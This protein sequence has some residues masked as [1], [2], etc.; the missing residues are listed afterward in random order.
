MNT[1]KQLTTNLFASVLAFLVNGGISFFLTP[2]ITKTLG[3]EAYGF[4]LLGTNIIS[5]ATL[6]TIALNSMAGRF[7]TIE[8]H[9]GN[10]YT[11]NRYFTSVVIAN[12]FVAL[13][14]LV[15]TCLFIVYLD[16]LFDVPNEILTD[17]RILFVFLF[18][19]FLIGLVISAFNVST[20]ATNKLYLKSLREIES[21]LIRTLLLFLLFIF[22]EPAVSYLGFA[23]LV[24]LFYTGL[25]HVYY[26]KKFLPNIRIKK[27]Y[28]HFKSVIEIISSGIWNSVIHVGQIMLQ[29][30]N[31]LIANLFINATAMGVLA[32]AST[33]PT[34][35]LLLIGVIAGVFMPDFTILYAQKKMEELIISIKRSMKILGIIINIPVAIIVAFGQEF[36]SL[37]VPTQ[38]ANLLQSLAII[39]LLIVVISGPINSLYGV[40]TVTNKLKLNAIVLVTTGV[41]NIIIVYIL[42]QTTNFGIYAIVGV[43]VAIGIIRNLI[44]TA[45]FG[46]KYLG[47]KWNTFFPEIIKSV[48][49][50]ILITI[51]GLMF[52]YFFTI[53][54][55]LAF[56]VFAGLTAFLG[57]L[58]NMMTLLS[59][60][61]RRYFIEKLK[62]GEKKVE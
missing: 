60:S 57:V 16:R 4:V 20:F 19:N 25:F 21:N 36:F 58:I 56:C 22:F 18:A 47:L 15:P 39:S 3:V 55:W 8:I 34:L 37:W 40:F 41:L 50:F 6:V 43:S 5:Y 42:L 51:I 1:Q 24:V 27:K 26:T 9:K 12:I 46:A 10:W 7:I 35:I 54:T 11:A 53:Q 29:G 30:L 49:G 48:I 14:M 23:T 52:S 38:D 31:L 45:P 17:V 59:K 32:V 33:I 13:L 28:F 61:E 62:R 44:F 2:Y